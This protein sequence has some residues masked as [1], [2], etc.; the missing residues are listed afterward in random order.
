LRAASRW[1]KRESTSFIKPGDDR[2]FP[3]PSPRQNIEEVFAEGEPIHTCRRARSQN[4]TNLTLSGFSRSSRKHSGDVG[5][6]GHSGTARGAPA[7][8]SS[9]LFPEGGGG[10]GDE[11]GAWGSSSTRRPVEGNPAPNTRGGLRV[12][13]ERPFRPFPEGA[14]GGTSW[15]SG[16][17][18]PDTSADG[19]PARRRGKTPSPL[20]VV[21]PGRGTDAAA[22]D[23]WDRR[24]G[25]RL[26]FQK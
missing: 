18:F 11:G 16:W 17:S 2:V 10:G 3:P 24:P 14:R 15:I 26:A 20:V 21:N 12:I 1:A 7:P 13:F 4:K 5:T 8:G 23:P 25:N 6:G 9:N 22:I 19:W